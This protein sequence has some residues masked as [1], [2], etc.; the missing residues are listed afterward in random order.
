MRVMDSAESL[1]ADLFARYSADRASLPAERQDEL[2]RLEKNDRARAI[3]DFIA[4]MTDRFA[5]AE[6]RRLFDATPELG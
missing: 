1:L 5:I 6:H 3:A 4:G 2:A